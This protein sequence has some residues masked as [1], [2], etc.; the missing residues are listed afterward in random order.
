MRH[1]AGVEAGDVELG[2]GLAGVEG[3]GRG[4]GE[5]GEGCDCE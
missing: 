2:G 1:A 5:E 3:S 4:G